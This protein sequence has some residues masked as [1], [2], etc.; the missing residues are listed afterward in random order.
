MLEVCAR[1]PTLIRDA[2]ANDQNYIASTWV[3]SVVSGR[4]RR[5]PAKT[6]VVSTQVDQLLDRHDTRAIVLCADADVDKIWG[7]CC[8]VANAPVPAVH[9]VYVRDIK[10]GHGAASRMLAHIGAKPL[11]ALIF[12]MAGPGLS[13]MRHRFKAA[14]EYPVEEFLAGR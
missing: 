8:F 11:E 5:S 10:R 7:W 2:Q 12:T 1:Y 6:K 9:Y 4:N 13:M 14:S 3:R